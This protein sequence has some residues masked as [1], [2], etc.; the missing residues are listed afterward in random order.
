MAPSNEFKASNGF[1]IVTADA[2]GGLIDVHDR[3]PIVLSAAD[4]A[5]WLDE[6]L[7]A[8]QAEL[9]LRSVAI[10]QK[11]STGLKWIVPWET[12]GITDLTLPK[13]SREP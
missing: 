5:L 9:L 12:S 1:T 4:A 3:R 2:Q 11:R 10:G 8:E 7:A 13:Q 6:G